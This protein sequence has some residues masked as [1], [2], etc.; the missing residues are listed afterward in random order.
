MTDA[1]LYREHLE[2]LDGYLQRALEEARDHGVELKGVLFHSGREVEYHADDHPV[3]FKPTPHFRRWVP[4]EG[5]E[6]VVLARPGQRPRVVV[7]RP[8]DYWYD[9]SPIPES[10]WQG[11]VDVT[12]VGGFDQV[13]AELG[14]LTW[15]AYVGDSPAAAGELG[16]PPHLIEPAALMYPLDWYRAYKTDHEVALVRDACEDAARAHLAA[17]DAFLEGASEYQIHE[18]YLE[19]AGELEKETP[20]FPISALDEKC[21]VLHYQFK[22]GREA[23]PGTVLLMDAGAATDGYA[24]DLTRTWARHDADPVFHQLLAGVDAFQRKLVAGVRPGASYVELHLEAHRHVARLLAEAGIF[25]VSAEEAYERG[26]TRPFFPHGLGHHLGIQVHDVGGRQT[27]SSGGT[28]APPE[29]HPYLRTTRPIE[30]GHLLTIEPGIY[31]IPMLLE[32]LRSGS[33]ASAVEWG[34]VDRLVSCG[35]IRIEDDVLCTAGEPRDLSRDLLP[36]PRG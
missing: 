21:S 8:Q 26:L 32:P 19:A 25:K 12:E 15:V 10:Y 22:R 14:N 24:S 6:H 35:G 20:F 29:G 2:I 31:F 17:R 33:D 18:R 28:T 16:V 4:V 30:P 34:L 1:T 27:S 7:V 9:P 3:N 13:A 11:E 23:A 36:G 5:P